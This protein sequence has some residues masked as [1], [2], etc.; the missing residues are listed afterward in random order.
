MNNFLLSAKMIYVQGKEKYLLQLLENHVQKTP[1]ELLKLQN[2]ENNF[3]KIM[4][5]KEKNSKFEVN[6]NIAQI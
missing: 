2:L 1:K 5:I 6:I 4:K 3:Q